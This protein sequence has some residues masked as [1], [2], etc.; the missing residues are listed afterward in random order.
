MKRIDRTEM[1]KI[2]LTYKDILQFIEDCG[3]TI[4]DLPLSSVND[5]DEDII[6]D[7]ENTPEGKVVLKFTT[8][9]NNGYLRVNYFWPDG[10]VEET[11]EH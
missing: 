8:V 2:N 1:K 7:A 9:Q 5:D 10:T 4:Y 3:Y 6:V 11:F